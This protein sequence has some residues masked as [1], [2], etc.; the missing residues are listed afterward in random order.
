[1]TYIEEHLKM[2][3][4]L[5]AQEDRDLESTLGN[6][7]RGER[8]FHD[9]GETVVTILIDDG[10]TTKRQLTKSVYKNL[11][12]R[13]FSDSTMGSTG[14]I[15]MSDLG[16]HKVGDGIGVEGAYTTMSGFRFARNFRNASSGDAATG[17]QYGLTSD[18][19]VLDFA[20]SE[21]RGGWR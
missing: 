8:T 11:R 20:G 9:A 17:S 5:L 21:A 7:L 15:K 13:R 14:L 16:S 2:T 10:S 19:C 1:M 12:R 3:K 4:R 6:L 18:L